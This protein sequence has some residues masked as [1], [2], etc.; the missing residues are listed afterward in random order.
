MTARDRDTSYVDS[1]TATVFDDPAFVQLSMKG[2][3]RLGYE[4]PWQAIIVRPVM[5]RE[6]W[7]LQISYFDERQDTTKNYTGEE[8]Y[9]H[10]ADVLAIPFS[11]ILLRTTVQDRHF[12][13]SKKG[14]VLQ[15]VSK[16]PVGV[17]VD[18]SHDA[19]KALPLADNTP[20]RYLQAVGIMNQQGEIRPKMRAKFNQINE[21]LKILDHALVLEGTLTNK[22]AS[23]LR[24]VDFGC[25]SAYLTLAAYHY[26][27]NIRGIASQLDGV[28]TNGTLIDK[29]TLHSRD[30]GWDDA[31]FT[32]A[33]ITNFQMEFTPDMVI[34]LHACDTATDDTL[35]QG[36]RNGA[37]IILSAPCC[38]HHLHQQLTTVDPMRPVMRHGILKKRMADIVT[39]A[40]R[41]LI[42]RIYGY[43]TDVIEFVGSEHTDRNL[44]IRAIKR[45]PVDTELFVAEYNALKAFWGVTPYLET[46][47]GA[48]FTQYLTR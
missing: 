48:D 9:T 31:C 35:A 17:T 2:K 6:A 15:R 12:R 26:L 39:D 42:L 41:A 16:P 14:K 45:E 30:L 37:R 46:H 36:I 43:T 34:S 3:V 19:D 28:D 13:I 27:N 1:I 25:G 24:I 4:T 5:L 32:T 23:P 10:L 40:F 18:H 7:H 47:L 38:H 8:A 11:D 20:D 22:D 44:M 21:F 29:N 33:A